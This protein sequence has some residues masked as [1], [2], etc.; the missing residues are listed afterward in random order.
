M[1]EG[2]LEEMRLRLVDDQKRVMIANQ[3][4]AKGG[5]RESLGKAWE[6]NGNY[7]AFTIIWGYH[8]GKTIR[9]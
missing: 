3:A 5:P 1:E 6:I 7:G 8:R 2:A 4:G 9:K